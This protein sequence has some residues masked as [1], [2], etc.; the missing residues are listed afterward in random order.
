MSKSALGRGLGA[1][2]GGISSTVKSAASSPALNLPQ[3]ST[4]LD[5]RERVELIPV[6]QIKACPFQPRRDFPAEAIQEL[7]ESMR[8]QGVLQPLI[9]RP[10]GDHY[11]LIAG[12]RRWRAAQ[13][14]G[15]TELP[16]L[17]RQADDQ[18]V[19][20]LA[21]IENLQ[22]ENLNAIDE[23]FGFVQLIKQFQLKQDEIAIRVGKSRASVANALRLLQL[24]ENLQ[25]QIQRGE[26]SVGHAKVI[27]GLS[28]P[29]DQVAVAARVI[30]EQLS[31]RESEELVAQ[32][33]QGKTPA[34]KQE[35]V[36]H[37]PDVHLNAMQQ[38]L[39]ERLGTK[40]LLR[41]RKGKGA[42]EIRFFSDD[43]LDRI[44]SILGVSID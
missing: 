41:Y 17:I 10:S 4:S 35:G 18:K 21:L 13:L 15:I 12:E 26:L 37:A 30:R 38:R 3:S 43:D 6:S 23:A 22:R 34:A 20:E 5:N 25:A 42:V 33:Q 14:T 24:P 32:I 7:A 19:L 40:V 11:E 39:Q 28:S 27:L 31:V 1:L 2:M 9:V 29:M 36:K 16:V 44:L 8:V